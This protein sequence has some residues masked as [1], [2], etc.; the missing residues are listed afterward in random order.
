MATFRTRQLFRATRAAIVLVAVV[1]LAALAG[2][3]EL[4]GPPARH[5][6]QSAAV[7]KLGRAGGNIR[8]VTITISADGTVAVDGP[9][10]SM[11]SGV[12]LS[13]DAIAGLL[14]LAQAERFNALPGR[15]E[16]ARI[17]P[18]AASLF[19]SVYAFGKAKTV[20]LH[21]TRNSRFDQLL[22]VLE[23]AAEVSF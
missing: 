20:Y 5:G 2:R 16:G 17:F 4:S 19:V 8:P 11:R 7:F 13:K 14:K 22:A 21:G 9:V 12:K 18:D 23:A 6:D 3:T 10:R 15:I 1:P